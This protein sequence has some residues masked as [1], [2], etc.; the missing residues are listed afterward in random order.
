MNRLNGEP[1]FTALADEGT[2]PRRIGVGAGFRGWKPLIAG[3][4]GGMDFFVMKNL[5]SRVMQ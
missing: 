5:W 3:L 2:N 1:G 4:I